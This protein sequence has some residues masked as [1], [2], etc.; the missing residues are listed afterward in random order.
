MIWLGYSLN[1]RLVRAANCDHDFKKK[2][3]WGRASW[4]SMVEGLP[5]MKS[6]I[7]SAKI[8]IEKSESQGTSQLQRTCCMFSS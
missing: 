3:K 6:S 5:S 8:G 1:V 2:K 7:L 4:C